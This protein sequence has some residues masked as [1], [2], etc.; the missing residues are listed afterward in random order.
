M[1]F[2]G[3]IVPVGTTPIEKR[4]KRPVR[5]G[6]PAKKPG[7]S[8]ARA[9]DEAELN[10]DRA[11]AAEATRGVSANDTEDARE[12]HES[13]PAYQPKG[14]VGSKLDLRG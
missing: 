5:A 2:I 10:V 6:V 11:E 7:E 1:P 8:F 9:A 4:D 12:D 13:H 14:P 3:S